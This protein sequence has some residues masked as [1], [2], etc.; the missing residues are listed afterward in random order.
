M[1]FA[2]NSGPGLE[3]ADLGRRVACGFARREMGARLGIGGQVWEGR[4]REGRREAGLTGWERSRQG[5]RWTAGDQDGRPRSHS[6]QAAPQ[7][8]GCARAGEGS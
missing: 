3:G 7:S 1:A 6:V 5:S 2:G 8:L 4:C